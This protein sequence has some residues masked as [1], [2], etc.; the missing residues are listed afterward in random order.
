MLS[1]GIGGGDF[2]DDGEPVEWNLIWDERIKLSMK[3]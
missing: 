3:S 2:Y 1:Y